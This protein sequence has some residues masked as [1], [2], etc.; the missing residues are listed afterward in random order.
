MA[1]NDDIQ[2]QRDIGA[3]ALKQAQAIKSQNKE[4]NKQQKDLV[5]LT[6]KYLDIVSKSENTLQ[7]IA[8]LQGIGSKLAKARGAAEEVTDGRLKSQ[9]T[10]LSDIV[11]ISGA[12]VKAAEKRLKA[13][14]KTKDV[15]QD[16][17]KSL[18][19][20]II[21]KIPG[22]GVLDKALGG[23]MSANLTEKLKIDMKKFGG[24][25]EKAK[26]E[27]KKLAGRLALAGVAIGVVTAMFSK[28]FDALQTLTGEQRSFQ[29]NIG[30]SADQA[31]RLAENTRNVMHSMTGVGVTLQDATAAVTAVAA[32]FDKLPDASGEVVANTL[33]LNR[34]LGVSVGDAAALQRSFMEMGATSSEA[35]QTTLLAKNLADA[36]GVPLGAITADIAQ[37]AGVAATY[38]KGSKEELIKSAVYAKQL[39]LS[40]GDVGKISDKILDIQGSLQSEMQASVMLGQNFNFDRARL[41]ALEGNMKAATEEVVQQI[42]KGRD[43]NKLNML[44]KQSLVEMTG[45]EADQLQKVAERQR[46]INNM[47]AAQ[48]A[49][50]QAAEA[51]LDNQ[52]K[53][54]AAR[55]I[56]EAKS[57]M[58]QQEMNATME[59]LKLSLQEALI[60][61]AEGMLPIMQ[62]LANLA[63][64]IGSVFKEYPGIIGAIA[65]GLTVIAGALA[66]AAI[67]ASGITLGASTLAMAGA[68]AVLGGIYTSMGV[69]SVP[70]VSTG[71]A[72]TNRVAAVEAANSR[73]TIEVVNNNTLNL[74]GQKVANNTTK[75][76]NKYQDGSK[77]GVG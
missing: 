3:E 43:F 27:V 32:Q 73:Q 50:L 11:S 39:G 9:V 76:Q 54:T 55:V 37:N 33:T 30:L 17:A 8:E 35:F 24:N 7:D 51:S 74:D 59:S 29:D 62:G 6:Q 4:I 61:L 21:G 72:A 10:K 48:K 34:L 63:G 2:K 65:A 19:D 45:L 14:E 18:A 22:L 31:F 12:A 46:I 66:V 56:Q 16:H 5:D 13:E 41:L 64:W 26:A 70:S 23:S 36:A 57:A 49:Q 47:T 25:T 67:A 15:L 38:F 1:D 69:G 71:A 42:A 68:A 20:D 60:P 77:V 28:A 53:L 75:Y 40:L 44:E 52:N 58:R